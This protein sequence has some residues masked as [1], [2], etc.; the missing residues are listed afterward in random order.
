MGVKKER[1]FKELML[2]GDAL[3]IMFDNVGVVGYEDVFVDG[4]VGRVLYEDIVSDKDIPPFDRAA[5]DGYAVRSIDVAG[6]SYNNPIRLKVV[7][8]SRASVGYDGV[9][10]EFEA[11]RIDTGAPLPEGSDAVVMLED[12]ESGGGYVDVYRSV[13]R[14]ANVSRRGEDVRKGE[15]LFRAGHLL[16]PFDVALIKNLGFYRVRVYRRLRISLASV[17]SELREVGEETG[18]TDIIES[19]RIMIVGMLRGWPVEFIRSLILPDDWSAVKEFIDLSVRDS[20]LIITTG[21]TSLG[22]GDIITDYIYSLGR[23]LFHGVALQPSKPVLF[24]VVGG[25]PLIGLPGYPVAA[26]IST[27]MFVEPLILRMCG[28]SGFRVPRLVEARLTRRVASRLGTLQVVRC[29][30]WREGGEYLVEPVY[31]SGAGVLSSL[32]RANSFLFIPENVEGYE[33]GLRV[34]V[35]VYR[36]VIGGG[37][38]L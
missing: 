20:D 1:G 31:A 12:A 9:V 18:P 8:E 5:M 2:V 6:A 24:A 22:R 30:V 17:G 32:G 13:S 10:G 7:G 16:H 15:V 36:E 38:G 27:Y 29:R 28:V 19:N 23:V 14:Y 3:K 37:E 25:K 21:G 34:R 35:Y 33:V 4:A 11:V 26:A